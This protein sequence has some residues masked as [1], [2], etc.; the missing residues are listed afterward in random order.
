MDIVTF[1]APAAKGRPKVIKTATGL[2][3]YFVYKLYERQ[4]DLLADVDEVMQPGCLPESNLTCWR[5]L[6]G[7]E[8]LPPAEG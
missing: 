8:F 1:N 2:T 4:I 5:V 7:R 3:W 6:R